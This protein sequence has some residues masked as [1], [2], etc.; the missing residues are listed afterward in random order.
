MKEETYGVLVLILS[1]L[2]ESVAGVFFKFSINSGVT[3]NQNA[4]FRSTF[5]L[6]WV[7]FAMSINSSKSDSSVL[8]LKQ[9]FGPPSHRKLVVLR[10]IC[11]GLALQLYYYT[12]AVLPLGDGN[13]LFSL[14]SV[15]AGLLAV[16]FL[17]EAL[18]I[19]SI[20]A[21]LV[22]MLGCTLVA[23][24]SFLFGR[25]GAYSPLGYMAGIGCATVV[26]AIVILLRKL[27]Q[28]GVVDPL[29]MY[30]SFCIFSMLWSTL[31]LFVSEEDDVASFYQIPPDSRVYVLVSCV[32]ATAGDFMLN[33]AAQIVPAALTS[34]LFSTS[35]VFGYVFEILV[36]GI[37]PN[38]WTLLGAFL[39]C[40]AT[41]IVA[42]STTATTPTTPTSVCD[43]KVVNQEEK[44]SLLARA[45]EVPYLD[46]GASLVV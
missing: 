28:S 42:T 5:Q 16:H 7:C 37:Q 43:S 45:K 26:A 1:N 30:F 10:G 22:S 13:T 36:F 27:G 33:F 39:V 3:S 12:L 34:I 15:I 32:F 29:Q 2:S 21:T 38:V 18:S 41:V 23:Q 4:F 11:G 25:E 14:N 40:V 20:V 8:L 46:Y 6:V 19:S 35:I 31:A 17:G 24:P 44:E 9:P